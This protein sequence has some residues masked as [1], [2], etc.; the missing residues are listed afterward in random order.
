MRW[1]PDKKGLITGLAVAGFGFGAMVWVKLAGAWLNLIANYGLDKTFMIYGVCFFVI[2]TISSLFMVFPPEGWQPEGLCEKK[3]SKIQK[4][5]KEFSSKEMLKT[6]DFHLISLT[7]ACGAGAGLMTIG[8]MKLFPMSALQANGFSGDMAKIISGNA[9]AYFFAFSN[10][11]GRV[12]WGQL[13]DRL[14]AR[15]CLVIMTAMQGLVVILFQWMVS[16]PWPLYLGATIIGFNF[17]GN[18]ALFPVIT[19][20]KFGAKSVGHNY[21]WVFVAYG[22]GGIFGPKIGGMLGNMGNFPLAFSICGVL[23]L[24]AAILISRLKKDRLI[25]T[26]A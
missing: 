20:E 25:A 22:V 21:G 13:S 14:G 23:C 12:I 1:Y 2:V 24:V 26:I 5:S 6:I 19:A 15:N 8:L 11:L 4:A 7:F 3:K 10:G 16:S 18:F 9:M 17:G